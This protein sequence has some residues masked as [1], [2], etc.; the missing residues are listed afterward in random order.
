MYCP[1]CGKNNAY[2]ATDI[3]MGRQVKVCPDCKC[4]SWPMPTVEELAKDVQRIKERMNGI[5]N[6]PELESN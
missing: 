5:E 4:V 6:M 2:E 3:N 1:K